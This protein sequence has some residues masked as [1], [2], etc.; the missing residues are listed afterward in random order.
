MLDFLKDVKLELS[1]VNWPT[2]QETVKYTSVVVIF[3]VAMA[4]FLGGLDAIF[5]F[6][7]NKFILN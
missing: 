5:T 3:S 7:L 1:R 2:K 6:V 4:L